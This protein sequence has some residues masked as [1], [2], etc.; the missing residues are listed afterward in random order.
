MPGDVAPRRVGEH[1]LGQRL[2]RLALE[3]DDLP[4]L[5]GAQ[6]LAEVQVAVDPLDRRAGRSRPTASKTARSP[7][8]YGAS[9]GTHRE[10]GVEPRGH[11]RGRASRALGGRASRGGEVLGQHRVDLGHRLAEP[12][13]ASAAKSPPTSSA[14][15]SAS[16]NRLRTLVS[17]S[18]QP[19]LAVRRNC[20]SIASW[21]GSP[22]ASSRSIRRASRRARRRCRSRRG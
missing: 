6:R 19:S 21:S 9:S 22:P 12:R 7:S 8:A 10:R 17:A 14:C 13:A 3:V 11:R 20:C 18:S 4:A 5:R 16:A 1:P 15:R 2:G